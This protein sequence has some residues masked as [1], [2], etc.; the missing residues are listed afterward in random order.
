MMLHPVAAT[1]LLLLLLVVLRGT[2]RKGRRTDPCK[3]V[4]G[5]SDFLYAKSCSAGKAVA[6]TWV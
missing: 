1:G 6:E 5:R 2:S 3:Q 4:R